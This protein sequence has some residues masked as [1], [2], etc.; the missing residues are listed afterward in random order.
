MV[1]IEMAHSYN[2]CS[3]KSKAI[4][5]NAVHSMTADDPVTNEARAQAA[6]MSTWDKQ[7]WC[8]IISIKIHGEQ[9]STAFHETRVHIPPFL[10]KD[11]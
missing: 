10:L 3:R 5:S 4:S 8:L 1:A 6:M 7:S 9:Q 11:K 2:P